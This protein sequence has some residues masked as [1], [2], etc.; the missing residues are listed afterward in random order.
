MNRLSCLIWSTISIALTVGTVATARPMVALDD[1]IEKQVIAELERVAAEEDQVRYRGQFEA[2][3][4]L[5]TP[6]AQLLLKMLRDEDR[7]LSERRRAANALQDVATAELVVPL[8]QVMGD[9]LLEPWVETE[10]GLLLARLGHRQFLDRWL[11]QVRR[12][13][14]QTPT[15]ASLAQILKAL[16]Q[17][18]D[19]QFRSDDLAAASATHRRRIALTEDLIARVHANWKQ[20]LSD[21]LWAIHYNLACCLARSNNINGAFQAL[22]KSLRAPTIQLSMVLVDGDLKSLRQDPIWPTWLAQQQKK[23]ELPAPVKEQ[24]EKR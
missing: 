12:I 10:V 16:S 7:P 21:E 8:Q 5:G 2:L 20:P 15:T 24:Q 9:L 23:T 17:L 14:D 19:L 6:A 13:S 11:Q 18:G 3:I 22:E 1:H 4:P